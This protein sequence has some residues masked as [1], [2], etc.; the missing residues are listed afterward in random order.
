[1]AAVDKAPRE[2]YSPYQTIANNGRQP[3]VKNGGVD[4]EDPLLA[5]PAHTEQSVK[6]LTSVSTVVAV[7]LLGEF[8]TN[9]DGTLVMA[10]AAPISSQFQRLQDA[11]WL[12]TG[13]T[14]SLCAAQPM[15]GKLSDIYGRKPVLLVAYAFFAVGCLIS[16]I[17]HGLWMVILGRAVSGIG[18]A[19]IMTLGSVIITADIVPR[20]DLA[21]W[22]AYI[23]IAMTLGRSVGGPLGG[24][25]TDAVGWRW[26][27]L[28]QIPFIAAGAIL[29]IVKLQIA[30]PDTPH[31]PSIRRVDFLGTALLAASIISLIT[32]LDRGGHA[33]PWVSWP[34]LLLFSS[35]LALGALFVA[36]ETSKTL[37][38]E[39]IFDLRILHNNRNVP[40]AYTISFLQT[41][42]QLGMVFAVPLYMQVSQRASTTR[43]GAHMI[44]SV[45]GNT[46]GGLLAGYVTRRTGRY[47]FLLIIA[48]PVAAVSYALLLARWRDQPLS[49][50]ESL[51]ILPGG[52]G[53]GICSAAAFV[54]MSALLEPG[55]VAMATS[56]YMLVISLAMTTGVTVTNT[57]LGVGFRRE[58]GRRLHGPEADE[59]IRRAV[60]DTNY[61]A[62]LEGRLREVV[63]RCYVDGL[64]GTYVISLLCSILG[65]LLGWMVRQH[66]L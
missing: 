60:S 15:Y 10:A 8:I 29:V 52:L 31:A 35:G 9:A 37:A 66:R 61:I 33:F 59:V 53:S 34:A 26:L 16:G 65:S 24:W 41:T 54:A 51:D 49:P 63:V 7:L 17:G 3:Y 6:L 25:L 12:S 39:P 4:E 43:A 14:L 64:Q 27:F 2:H 58:L 62:G 30:P 23:N 28:L 1:M 47:K 20:R 38:P 56:G 42:A 21:S 19:G 36:V 18:G 48:G 40:I 45:A 55:E 13:Y 32:V 57:V 50:W 22:R 11:S 5:R 46:L 44:P